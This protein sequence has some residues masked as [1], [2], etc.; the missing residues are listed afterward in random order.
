METT[1]RKTAMIT[2]FWVTLGN[3]S[4][5]RLTTTIPQNPL[6]AFHSFHNCLTFTLLLIASSSSSFIFIFLSKDTPR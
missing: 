4:A 6:H 2:A 5:M 3:M 1:I